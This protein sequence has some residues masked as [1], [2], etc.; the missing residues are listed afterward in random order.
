MTAASFPERSAPFRTATI[1]AVPPELRGGVAAIGNFDGV[2]RGHQEV[3]A[4]AQT[5]ARDEE[6][7]AVVLTFEPHPRTFFRP[8]PPVFRLTPPAERAVVLEALGL[9]GMVL[10]PFDEALAAT[11]PD[12]FV[13]TILRDRLGVTGAVVGYNFHF[14]HK[15]RGT[16]DFLTAR[17]EAD[18]FD[19]A[20][21]EP[22]VDAH[23]EPISS[24]RIR[25]ALEAGSPHIAAELLGYRWL[26]MG[27]VAHGDK[28]GR[29]LG[30]PTANIKLDP[31]CELK[32]G[33]YAVRVFVDGERFDG[34]ASFGRRPM[35][36]DGAP[37][38]ETFLFDFSGD[39]YGKELRISVFEFLRPELKFD[40]VEALIQQ[41]DAD[42]A[43]AR[44]HLDAATPL[45]DLDAALSFPR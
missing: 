11:E 20:V 23:G 33:V 15:R 24:T 22:G 32:H 3:L 21:I 6:G 4:A 45:S 1:D 31:S 8:D 26:V 41:M 19:V 18:G 7:P 34:V 30:Y 36:D 17:G 28:R 13:D 10:V 42:S 16:P 12:A 38:F 5:L 39:L 37:L 40:S 14:G 9:D 25:T 43:Q 35:F 44:R 2:H 29:T 27:A